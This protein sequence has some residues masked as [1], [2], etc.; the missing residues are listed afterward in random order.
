MPYVPPHLRNSSGGSAPPPANGAPSTSTSRDKYGDRER[1]RDYGASFGGSRRDAWPPDK[2]QSQGRMESISSGPAP[3]KRGLSNPEPVFPA[4][5]PSKRAQAMTAAQIADTRERLSITLESAE[6]SG[7][8]PA[9]IE[10]FDDMV[11]CPTQDFKESRGSPVPSAVTCEMPGQ[12]SVTPMWRHH[13]FQSPD[14]M[15]I[16]G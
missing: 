15:P 7:E 14:H 6:G 16:G 2:G 13:G 12:G 11:S 9:P 5:Q 1:G 3:A 4:W 8:V 10:S